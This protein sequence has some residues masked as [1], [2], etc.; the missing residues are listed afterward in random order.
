MRDPR[1]FLMDE[2]LSNLD[3][4]LRVQMRLELSR[5]QASLGTTT[6][7]VTHDQ[8]EAMTLGDRLAVMHGGLIQQ[9]GTPRSLY[10]D[11]ANLFVAG[12]IGSPPISFVPGQLGDGTL[13]LPFGEASLPAE[14]VA[15]LTPAAARGE[16]IAGIRPEAFEDAVVAGPDAQGL[17]LRV[18]LDALE[19][20]GPELFAYFAVAGQEEVADALRPIGG[21]EL[22]RLD[23]LAGGV[24]IVARLDARSR[25][26]AGA[27]VDLVLRTGDIKLFDPASGETLLAPHS[28][29]NGADA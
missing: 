10:D 25:A 15:R 12:F 17:R 19:A 9:V 28:P 24:P 1:A 29:R 8:T 21:D 23:S 6:I 27:E 16:V 4:K 14:L 3:A 20:M 13:R 2:P 22:S 26:A 11:P 7:Y 5:L 18:K